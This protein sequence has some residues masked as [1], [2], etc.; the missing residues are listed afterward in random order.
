MRERRVAERATLAKSEHAPVGRA[1]PIGSG[2]PLRMLV[3]LLVWGGAAGSAAARE[4]RAT[5]LALEPSG[6][7][8]Q[9]TLE[10]VRYGYFV[11]SFLERRP[12]EGEVA[13]EGSGAPL[14]HRDRTI[15]KRSLVL[16]IGKIPFHTIRSIELAYRPSGTPGS[17]VLVLRV[18]LVT[19]M[20]RDVPATDLRGFE[21][22]REPFLEGREGGKARRFALTPFRPEGGGEGQ[23]W[24][25]KVVFHTRLRGGARSRTRS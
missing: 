13:E 11:R 8:T 14:R 23:E 25:E 24:L 19:G 22:F 9:I 20:E 18:T 17:E 21:S 12:P 7:R 6:E 3:W 16:Q 10:D 15:R 1:A 4:V 2:V 5:F